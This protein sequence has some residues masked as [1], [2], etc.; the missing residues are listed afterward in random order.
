MPPSFSLCI[1]RK[2][3]CRNDGVEQTTGEVIT[4]TVA[5][6]RGVAEGMVDTSMNLPLLG[7]GCW[8]IGKPLCIR[9]QKEI[10]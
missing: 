8:A 1:R 7:L 9:I 6:C 10:G 5:K 3:H 4:K 2:V